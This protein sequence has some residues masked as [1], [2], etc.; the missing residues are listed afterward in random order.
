MS[1]TIEM[2]IMMAS[3]I[4]NF[5]SKINAFVSMLCILGAQLCSQ[6]KGRNVRSAL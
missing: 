5:T 1:L 2:F 6:Q 4:N 3:Q